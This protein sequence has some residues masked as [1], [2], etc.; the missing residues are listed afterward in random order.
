MVERF[1]DIPVEKETPDSVLLLLRDVHPMAELLYVD[2]GWWWVGIVK[3][4]APA[5]EIARQTL[6]RMRDSHTG[7]ISERKYAKGVTRRWRLQEQG[8]ALCGKYR[9]GDEGADFDAIVKDFEFADWVYR[10]YGAENEII[11]AQLQESGIL[12]DEMRLKARAAT[13]ERLA[14]DERYLF[15]RLIRK[16]PRPVTVGANIT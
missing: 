8:F 12:E 10:N 2:Y 4:E 13:V 9:F 7:V 15:T 3:P 11:R 1:I 5:R 16:N 6:E 14:A